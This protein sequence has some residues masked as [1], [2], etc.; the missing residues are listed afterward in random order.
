MVGWRGRIGGVT[1]ERADSWFEVSVVA[2]GVTRIAEGR[3]AEDVKSYLVEGARDV[4]V[5]DTGLGVGDFRGLVR[6]LSAR[7]PIVLQTHGHWDHFGAS[8]QFARVLIHPSEAYALRRGFPNELYRWVMGGNNVKRAALPPGFDP[9]TAAIPAVEPTGELNHGDVINLGGRQLEVLHTPGHSPGGV[10]FV[11][12][13]ARLLFPGDAVNS[14]RMWL[15]LPRSDPAAWRATIHQL[16][17]LAPAIDAIY[18]AHGRTPLD[19]ALLPRMRD[20]FEQVWSGARSPDAHEDFDIGFPTPVK[21][22]IFD[23]DG[24][25]FYLAAG[26]YGAAHDARVK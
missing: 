5:I 2:P 21:T 13:D 6:R 23:F 10:S 8:S 26:R 12:R 25:G 7:D 11:D 14:G 24:F 19:P 20:A 4:A 1:D 17:E 18:C 16:A 15:H 9:D 22:D 3:H